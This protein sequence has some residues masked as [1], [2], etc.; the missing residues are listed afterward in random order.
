MGPRD[1][2]P[3]LGHHDHEQVPELGVGGEHRGLAAH[4]QE[5]D[6]GVEERE[7]GRD[8][9]DSTVREVTTYTKLLSF[10]FFSLQK[11]NIYIFFLNLR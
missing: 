11:F 3:A 1:G 2:G 4:L 9:S 10:G 7:R 5:G 6:E 8:V